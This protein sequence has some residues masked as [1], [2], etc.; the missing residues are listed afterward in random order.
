LGAQV[1]TPSVDW[2]TSV[3]G[4]KYLQI[5]DKTVGDTNPKSHID[6]LLPIVKTICNSLLTGKS[7]NT[8]LKCLDEANPEDLLYLYKR[9]IFTIFEDQTFTSFSG[10]NL[11]QKMINARNSMLKLIHT[12]INVFG[13]QY[14]TDGT[15]PWKNFKDKMDLIPDNERI[16]YKA[17]EVLNQ[18]RE[19][20]VDPK[21][22]T[23]LESKVTLFVKSSKTS[24]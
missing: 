23:D 4:Y 7:D 1:T 14:N 15:V 10:G 11:H 9:N 17:Q 21:N 8:D 19:P 22:G 13:H 24:N 18:L 5:D 2:Y 12:F 16:E 6:A 20:H 3:I